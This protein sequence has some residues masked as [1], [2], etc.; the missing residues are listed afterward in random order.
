MC[1]YMYGVRSTY[2]TPYSTW[3]SWPLHCTYEKYIRRTWPSS[4]HDLTTQTFVTVRANPLQRRRGS[5]PIRCIAPSLAPKLEKIPGQRG[6]TRGSM[7]P[8]SKKGQYYRRG[9]PAPWPRNAWRAQAAAV[10][11]LISRAIVVITWSVTTYTQDAARWQSHLG[12]LQG[13]TRAGRMTGG[14]SKLW[15]LELV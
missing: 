12:I 7:S 10:L 14:R 3:G 8:G 2:I 4:F 9:R 11:C 13:S 5:R 1:T 6:L 15:D